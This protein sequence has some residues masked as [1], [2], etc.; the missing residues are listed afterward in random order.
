MNADTCLAATEMRNQLVLQLAV[1]HPKP[2]IAYEMHEYLQK[3]RLKTFVLEVSDPNED[4]ADEF[5]ETVISGARI[6]V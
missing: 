2:L 6:E 5:D 1:L 3:I 4:M